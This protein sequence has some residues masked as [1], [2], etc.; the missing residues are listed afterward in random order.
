MLIREFPL[1]V[2][3]WWMNH[4]LNYLMIMQWTHTVVVFDDLFILLIS[5]NSLPY[6]LVNSRLTPVV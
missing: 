5:Q 1:T 2:A 4:T 6:T 3:A